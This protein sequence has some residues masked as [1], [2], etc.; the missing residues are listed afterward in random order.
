MN[1]AIGLASGYIEK[2]GVHSGFA[3][4]CDPNVFCIEYIAKIN[5][6]EEK[7]L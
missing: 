5:N 1:P 2:G 3:Q 7:N 4:K 6:I